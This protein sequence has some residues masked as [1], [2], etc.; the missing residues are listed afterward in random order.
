[1]ILHGHATIGVADHCAPSHVVNTPN[2]D[3]AMD[4]DSLSSATSKGFVVVST[5]YE[6]LGGPGRHPFLVGISEARSML[7]AGLA[8]RQLPGVY[9]GAQTAA[10]GFSQG[11]H[12]ALWAAQLAPE[13]TPTQP[14]FATVVGAPSSEVAEFARRGVEQP[15]TAPLSVSI[16][17]GLA[18]SYPEAEAALGS[19]LTSAGTELVG[20]MDEHCFDESVAMPSGSLLHADPTA[21]EPFASLLAANTA[22]AVATGSP[23]LVFHGDAD[24]NI[25]IAHSDALLARL[26]AAGQV[27]E[28]RV[29]AGGQHTSAAIGA[30]QEGVDWLVTV[31]DGTTTPISSCA[32]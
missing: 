3:Y 20:L 22:G 28:R 31:A 6:G 13:W 30:Y 16:L 12:A 24:Q 27:V 7:D 21:V 11:G 19:V 2:D 29:L 15:E 18:A 8:A 4:F 1:M 26:C 25:P 32:G 14:I 9:V 17:A 5:D 10:V 23:L